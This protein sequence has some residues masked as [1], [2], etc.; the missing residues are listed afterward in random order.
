MYYKV[1]KNGRVIDVL[2]R[3]TFL[4]YQAMFDRMI[5][6][7]RQ[8][9]QGILSSDGNTAWHE[10][11]L[12]AIPS[13]A[14]ETVRISVIDKAEYDQLRALCCKTPEEIIDSYTVT[15]LSDRTSD[16]FLQSLRRL[17]S[18]GMVGEKDLV[19]AVAK[20]LAGEEGI[21]LL[22]AEANND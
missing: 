13:A 16:L 20:G 6:C 1:I 17:Y 15:L 5:I 10:E 22:L 9:A 12:P 19:S 4:R 11:S 18:A 3:L 14:Y 21:S 7:D 8:Q 2:D